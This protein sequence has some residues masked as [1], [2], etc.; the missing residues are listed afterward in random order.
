MLIVLVLA[1][2]RFD[3]LVAPVGVEL[4]EKMDRQLAQDNDTSAL[5]Y[6]PFDDTVPRPPG[7]N[8]LAISRF[9]LGARFALTVAPL[10]FLLVFIV[11]DSATEQVFANA[12][13]FAALILA[14]KAAAWFMLYAFAD[15]FV[16]A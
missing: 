2:V 13:T 7:R 16:L 9:I 4:V 6:E 12:V 1:N 10:L 15:V 8:V 11:R 5:S 14:A 3:V